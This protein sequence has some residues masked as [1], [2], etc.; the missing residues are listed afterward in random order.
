VIL[1]IAIYSIEK[2]EVAALLLGS[3]FEIAINLVN[4][5]FNL[6][7]LIYSLILPLKLDTTAIY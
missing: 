4:N 1:T 7:V 5:L 2:L 3:G 6:Q